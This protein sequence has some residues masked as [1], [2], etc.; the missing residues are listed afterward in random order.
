MLAQRTDG[1]WSEDSFAEDE[2]FVP[3]RTIGFRLVTETLVR[4]AGT[5]G[6]ARAMVVR[7]P[8]IWG[9]GGSGHLRMFYASAARL[10]AV[11]YLGAGLNLYS[12]V[13]V[14]DLAQV[15]R[16]A[17]ERGTPGALYHAVAGEV[18]N[19]TIAE[20]VAADLGL[21]ARS[22]D[23]ATGIA[24]WGKFEALIGMAVCSRSRSPR[25]RRELGWQPRHRDLLSEIGHPAYRA[26]ANR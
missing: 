25:T 17:L 20:A 12:H 13:H 6:T 16:L 10:G 22:I 14:D 2:P 5:S 8:A 19:R 23:L 18:N 26:L 11:G 7:P 3:A 21:P 9:N 4:E 15:Y 1:E 24:C